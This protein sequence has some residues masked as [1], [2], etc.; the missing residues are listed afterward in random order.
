MEELCKNIKKLREDGN[1]IQFELAKYLNITQATYSKYELG[2]VNIPID[3]LIKLADF[4][5]VSLD[6]LVGRKKDI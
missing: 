4:Y 6:Y 3:V 2:R 5:N 1:K